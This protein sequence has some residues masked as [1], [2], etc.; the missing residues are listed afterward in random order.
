MPFV[1]LKLRP[2]VNVE[3]T[4]TQNEAGYS[5]S[6]LIRFFASLAQKVGGWAKFLAFAV[7]G[8][9]RHMHAW[10]DLNDVARVAVGTTQQ[11]AA[12]ST[13]VFDDISPQQVVSEV[14][15]PGTPNATITVTIATPAVV[16]WT[17]SNFTAGQ[18]VVFTTT[19]A[20]PTGMTA[21]QTYYVIAAGLTADTFQFSA[22][23]G[24]AAV[25]TSGIQSGVHTGNAG[26]FSTTMGS[27]TVT[28]FDL[29]ITVLTTYDAVEIKTPIAVGGLILQGVYPIASAPSTNTYTITASENATST[30]VRGGTLANFSTTANQTTCTVALTAHGLEVDDT[31]TWLIG[32]TVGSVEILGTYPVLTVPGANSFTIGLTSQAASTSSRFQNLGEIY[33]VYHITLGPTATVGTGYGA[34]GYGAGGYGSGYTLSVQTGTPI[35]AIDYTLD[36]WGDTLLACPEN[37]GIYAW[38]PNTGVGN[39][40][41]VTTAP[42]FNTGM[43]VSSQRQILICYG[44]TEPSDIGFDQDPLLVK[45]SSVSDYTNFVASSATQAGNYRIP[46]GSLV[47][48]GMSTPQ[49]EL[50]WTD[51][52]AYAMNYVGYPEVY[53]FN[54]IGSSCGLVAKHAVVTLASNIYWMGKTGFFMFGRSSVLPLPCTVWDAVFQNIDTDQVQNVRA[55]ANTP[56]NEVWWFYPSTASADG[57]NDSYVKYNTVENA[58]DYGTLARSACIDQS[59]VGPPMAATPSG[60]IY[61]HETGNDA[62]GQAINAWFETGWFPLSDGQFIIFVD[63]I[64]P[65]MKWGEFPGDGGAQIQMTL[66]SAMYPGG[67]VRTYGPYTMTEATEFLSTRLRG[68]LA[69]IRIESN[70][71]GSFWRVGGIRY[72]VAQDGRQ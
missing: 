33:F 58:W 7:N 63:W 30:V 18:P 31:V 44:S 60:I 24:G 14:L 64:M 42:I 3:L 45:W 21:G 67:D 68:R 40:Q 48:G 19:G 61:Q 25:N 51:L 46:T 35:T 20:L 56:F 5:A 37:G 6:Q 70:D 22:T 1:T 69:K 13:G 4:P 16:T 65:D 55:W 72:R 9:P 11:L 28:V 17:A 54:K 2:G 39:A 23:L 50:I 8:V 27:P 38:R 57:E 62:D 36:N 29:N 32:T 12:V 66:Y 34:G 59:V 43:F 53:G 41:L 15:T 10:Q 47:V 71:V 49:Q 52:D 26:R